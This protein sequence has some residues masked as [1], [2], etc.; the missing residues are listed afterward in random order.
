MQVGS[1]QQFVKSEGSAEDYGPGKFAAEDVQVGVPSP[2]S[3]ALCFSRPLSVFY[4]RQVVVLLGFFLAL[5][6][7]RQYGAAVIWV[8]PRLR[9]A[10][11]GAGHA[12]AKP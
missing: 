2:V 3:S 8:C 11:R 10:Y 1:F 5:T 9:A 6:H 4:K 7:L 12:P